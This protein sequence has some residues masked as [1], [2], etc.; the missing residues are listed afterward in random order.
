MLELYRAC[1][2]WKD[3]DTKLSLSCVW[4]LVFN[5]DSAA[6]KGMFHTALWDTTATAQLA[7]HLAEH[8]PL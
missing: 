5:S 8:V 1:S 4:K 6:S 7:L 2:N 3:V